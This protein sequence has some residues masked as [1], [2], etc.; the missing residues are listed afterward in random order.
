ME[1]QTQP[2]QPVQPVMTDK[3]TTP[4]PSKTNIWMIICIVL[5]TAIVVGVVVYFWIQGQQ[6][7]ELLPGKI[8]EAVSPE[9][10]TTVTETLPTSP[11]KISSTP[12]GKPELT[13]LDNNWNKYTNPFLGFSLKVPKLM[14]EPYGQ[15]E[16]S[17][18]NGDN[19]FRP[20]EAA[21]PVKIFEDKD[22]VF[23]AA[24]YNYVLGGE[25]KNANSQSLFAKCDKTQNTVARLADTEN[26]HSPQWQIVVKTINN[27]TE[28]NQ[29]IKTRYGEGCSIMNQDP[30]TQDGVF[31]IIVKGDDLD[32]SVSKCI[33]N[34]MS[35]I[36]YYPAK[37][38]VASWHIGQAC[39]FYYPDFEHCLDTDM[40]NSFKFE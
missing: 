11:S 6:K 12:V 2:T 40:T 16:F 36:R 24:E 1:K 23:I 4:P 8:T 14:T 38:K 33:I 29:F 22:S 19:S 21:V 37:N 39:N 9:I 34:Y 31:K 30:T 15:C 35:E 20:K 5:I 7:T 32:W 26:Y 25:S 18:A 10:T 3:P 27:E 13:P 17:T 28:L